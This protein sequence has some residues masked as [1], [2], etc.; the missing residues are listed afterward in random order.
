M[1]RRR[2]RNQVP[3]IPTQDQAAPVGLP[4]LP[5]IGQQGIGPDLLDPM[6]SVRGFQGGRGYSGG[7]GY[8]SGYDSGGGGEYTGPPAPELT[9]QEEKSILGSVMGG[10]EY[11]GESIEKPGYAVR[12]LMEG[13]PKAALNLIPFYDTIQQSRLGKA[14]GLPEAPKVS[15]DESLTN[16]FGAPEN[17]PGFFGEGLTRPETWDWM[18]IP[19][20]GWGMATNPITYA[21]FLPK[22]T[23]AAAAAGKA[24][25]AAGMAKVAEATAGLAE[26]TPEYA[27]AFTKAMQPLDDAAIAASKGAAGAIEGGARPFGIAVK[28]TPAELA[29]QVRQ[30][31]RAGIGFGVPFM[32]PAFTFGAGNKR[33]AGAI[34]AVGYSQPV[35]ALRGLFSH[36]PGVGGVANPKYQKAADLEW[37]KAERLAAITANAD[38]AYRRGIQPLRSLYEEVAEGLGKQGDTQAFN[39]LTRI[40]KSMPTGIPEG[41]D[42]ADDMARSLGVSQGALPDALQTVAQSGS[43]YS[44]LLTAMQQ[45]EDE[46]HGLLAKYGIPVGT[47]T[48]KTARY[49]PSPASESIAKRAFKNF[50]NPGK[51]R[52]EWI[53]LIPQRTRVAN[54]MVRD[55]LLKGV[56]TKEEALGIL[57]KAEDFEDA[58][59]WL[60][61]L[62]EAVDLAPSPDSLI[63]LPANYRGIQL[64][65]ALLN[66]GIDAGKVLG[67]NPSVAKLQG[68]YAKVVH[69]EPALD[70]ALKHGWIDA[71][72]REELLGELFGTRVVETTGPATATVTKGIERAPLPS[73][74]AKDALSAIPIDT[75]AAAKMGRVTTGKI[76]RNGIDR[77]IRGINRL[78]KETVR[79]GIWDKAAVDEHMEYMQS[80]IEK[81]YNGR[82]VFNFMKTKG[83]IEPISSAA[84]TGVPLRE[85]WKALGL[86]KEG[87]KNLVGNAKV[88]DLQV[89]ASAA[90]VLKTMRELQKPEVTTAYGDLWNKITSV[91]K[92]YWTI[93]RISFHARNL[94]G[95]TVNNLA[96]GIADPLRYT[97]TWGK[98]YGRI[99][100]G[101][102][103]SPLEEEAIGLGVLSDGVLTDINEF[104]KQGKIPKGAT[105]GAYST[106]KRAVLHPIQTVR[107]QGLSAYNPLNVGSADNAGNVVAQAGNNM[108][109]LVEYM[110]RIPYY[111][112]LREQGF[113]AAE[114]A[115]YVKKANFAYS[116]KSPFERK[117]LSKIIPFWGWTRNNL[118]LQI[119]RIMQRPL[120]G[121][122]GVMVK[123]MTELASR[124]DEF[125]PSF[126]REGL[127]VPVGGPPEARRYI[128]Q[129][130]MPLED[131]N[132][133]VYTGDMLGSL[134]R[135]GQ[136]WAASLHP[137]LTGAIEGLSGTQMYT[138]RPMRELQP[139]RT[140]FE[141]VDNVL[142]APGVSSLI[143]YSP[144][145]SMAGDLGQWFDPRKS[146]GQKALS[147]VTGIKTGTYDA[148]L[149]KLYELQRAQQAMAAD[150]PMVGLGSYAYL[151]PQFKGKP[152]SEE[153]AKQL[154]QSQGLAKLIRKI[155][156]KREMAGKKT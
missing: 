82:T 56:V 123:G 156:S 104:A 77:I 30:G 118:P 109:S 106:L 76:E 79:T 83:V 150:N 67:S 33:L 153:P 6:A 88:S 119:K 115:H 35:A 149:G 124:K 52:R 130:G 78:P 139:V 87:L 101:T 14:V 7:A 121:P 62:V 143:H 59:K 135:T 81:L 25:K 108:Y 125:V 73:E 57:S 20:F 58:P 39:D 3:W 10:I 126:M 41:A 86:T 120:G 47:W 144:A 2:R 94:Q 12:G 48:D 113:S 129:S 27:A 95:G 26:G 84:S 28:S 127:G 53:D 23:S 16:V 54:E 102:S 155:R 128:K 122:T 98:V 99:F 136:K 50:F 85:E 147:T 146:I 74:I 140:G 151:K 15:E 132:R 116:D 107:E 38:G 22:V 63:R 71:T 70:D 137:A 131:L 103:P 1:A 90:R 148:E 51:K 142:A 5:A 145:A 75:A 19:R 133:F 100:K 32:D 80:M 11:L 91:F 64:N 17:T 96:E 61:S 46:I 111:V 69:I 44:D 117:V 65:A 114:A 105:G 43:K 152:G 4:A 40:W 29:E 112:T 49:T 138:G 34:E 36:V 24:A 110:N 21:S 42:M 134:K 37:A 72:E 89:S 154:K 141:S 31:E 55:K 9:P 92:T 93:P 60:E 8:D 97:K 18:D 13:K 66:R 45:S 68:L